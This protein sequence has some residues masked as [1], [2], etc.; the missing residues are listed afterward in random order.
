MTKWPFAFFILAPF[1]I[2]LNETYQQGGWNR[3]RLVNLIVCLLIGGGLSAAQYIYNYIFLPKDLYNIKNIIGLVTSFSQA[4]G[5]PAW[6]TSA[7][8]LY[9]STTLINHQ[10]SFIFVILFFA[11]IPVLFKEKI[12]SRWVLIM[13]VVVP[14]I[15]ATLLP[16]KEQRITAPYL[17]VIAVISAVGLVHI[18][19][20]RL[21]SIAVLG[22]ISWGLLTW[23]ANSWGIAFLPPRL[24]QQTPL[25]EIVYFDQHYVLSPRD[26]SLQPGDWKQLALMDIICEDAAVQGINLPFEVPLVANTAAYNPNTLNYISILYQTKLLFL[27]TWSWIG[28]PLSLEDYPYTYLVW[29]RGK[30]IEIAGWDKQQIE[31]AEIYIINHPDA[32]TMIYQAPLPDETEILVYRHITAQGSDSP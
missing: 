24:V 25:A 21:R 26:Y 6:N 23:W 3:K 8:L 17:S 27:Y 14:Y 20:K 9:Y 31:N 15:L 16:V 32:F 11:S 5:H 19:G 12:P 18:Q 28:K 10:V 22:V 13:S 1:L 7:G 4:A 30:N 29:K 2:V